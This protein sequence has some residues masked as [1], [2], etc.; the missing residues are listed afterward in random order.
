MYRYLKI[1]FSF[2]EKYISASEVP[3]HLKGHCILIWENIE[4][5]EGGG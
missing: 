4:G 5:G 2:H 3:N 1:G